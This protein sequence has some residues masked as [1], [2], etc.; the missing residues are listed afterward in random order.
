MKSALVLSAEEVRNV[1]DGEKDRHYLPMQPQPP[2]GEFLRLHEVIWGD[3]AKKISATNDA[4]DKMAWAG[5][6]DDR[7]P[8]SVAY[9]GCQYGRPGSVL[10]IR[11]PWKFADWTE[12]GDPIIEY[13]AD[14]ERR[15]IDIESGIPESWYDRL[16]DIWADLSDPENY[17]IDHRAADRRWRAA[18]QM[19]LWAARIKI[20]ITSVH[21]QVSPL[22]WLIRFER[23]D[24]KPSQKQADAAQERPESDDDQDYDMVGPR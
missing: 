11:E 2:G 10:L 4:C 23:V 16:D 13:Q 20:C 17:A 24:N 18:T 5:F 12:S 22:S 9:Y 7:A 6:T 8:G 3:E 21:L 1:L 15:L 14:R 19:P